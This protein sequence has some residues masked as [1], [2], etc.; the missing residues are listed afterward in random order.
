M[1][2]RIIPSGET[3]GA[4]IEGLDLAAVSDADAEAAIQALGRHGVIR[5]PGQRL[6]AA[7]L[8]DFSARLGDL[9]VNVIGKHQE[10]GMPEVMT[11]SNVVRDGKSIGLPDAG[12]GWHTDMS[13]S[14]TIAFANVLYALEVP[15]REG[16]TLGAT[17]FCDMAAAWDDLPADLQRRLEGLTALHDFAKFYDMMRLRP[18]STRPP[19]SDEQRRTKPPVS[20]PMAITHPISGRKSLYA[21]PGYTIRVNGLPQAESDELLAFLFAHQTQEKYLYTFHWT[22]HDVLVWDNFRCIHQAVA[23]YGPDEPRLM[24]RCQVMASK[25]VPLSI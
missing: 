4:T 5:F 12:Q 25:Y 24:K 18:G 22:K 1:S 23:D 19:L 13:Y 17:Q 2:M 6:A 16:R 10:P 11:L 9:E 7:D 8:R 20:H 14:R 3:L 15:Q 21:N